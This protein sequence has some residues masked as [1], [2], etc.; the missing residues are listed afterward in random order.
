MPFACPVQFWFLVC[1]IL[2]NVIFGIIIDSF[3]E[4]RIHRQMIRGK[5]DNECFICGID[6]FTFDTKGDGF[7]KH[8]E[9]EHEKWNY[10]FMLVMILEKDHND[11]N[12]WESHVA[13]HMSP[14][15]SAFMP[16]SKALSLEEHRQARFTPSASLMARI[17]CLH[18]VS[19]RL[20]MRR[21]V[22]ACS[23]PSSSAFHPA[24]DRS[25][26]K[27]RS[28]SRLRRSSAQHV[29]CR[30]SRTRWMRSGS[31]KKSSRKSS[32]SALT[33]V[34]FS[35]SYLRSYVVT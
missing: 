10:L 19:D 26:R 20:T 8:R 27:Q 31:A 34:C 25:E 23:L 11:Y 1:I 5:I 18:A 2:L 15:N 28:R 13:K 30:T 6:R 24:S 7:E 29:L 35:R 9:F 16:R 21:L 3:G 4:L 32:Q 22:H 17:A 14:P 12:G 33:A